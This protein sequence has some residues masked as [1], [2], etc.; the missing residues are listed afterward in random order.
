MEGVQAGLLHPSTTWT[1]WTTWGM[2]GWVG[3]LAH[4]AGGY[5]HMYTLDDLHI[6]QL[7]RVGG[8]SAHT[9]DLYI[10]YIQKV[11]PIRQLEWVGCTYS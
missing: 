6:R 5:V 3:G 2:R 4:T 8:W 10:L 1:T 9:H 11:S 7:Q